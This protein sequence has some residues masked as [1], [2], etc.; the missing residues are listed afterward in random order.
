MMYR[1]DGASTRSRRP[2][3]APSG[4]S[5]RAHRS[6]IKTSVL[7]TKHLSRV[8]ALRPTRRTLGSSAALAQCRCA[9]PAT[10]RLRLFAAHAT[11]PEQ[12][13][14]ADLPRSECSRNTR[15]P[16]AISTERFEQT[17][18]LLDN[19][20]PTTN[21]HGGPRLQGW[22]CGEHRL[23]AR[24]VRPRRDNR[25]TVMP[26]HVGV[27]PAPAEAGVRLTIGSWNEALVMPAFRLSLTVCRA[28]PP[29]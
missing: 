9:Q 23:V 6:A 29:K 14:Y 7:R 10:P 2:R 21:V 28:A 3:Q 15:R 8:G 5:T 24:F 12:Y 4:G 20:A 22:R 19:S 18:A 11:P 17:K 13:P 27:E 26:R 25:G 1:A 16:R